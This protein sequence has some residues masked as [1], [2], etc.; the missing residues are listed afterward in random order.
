MRRCISRFNRKFHLA[1][2]LISIV[3]LILAAGCS[4]APVRDSIPPGSPKGYLVFYV[5]N[6]SKQS[7]NDLIIHVYKK[8]N[9]RQ[10][11]TGVLIKGSSEI[12]KKP[13]YFALRPGDHSFIIKGSRVPAEFSVKVN[14]GML[15]PVRLETDNI[16]SE[17]TMGGSTKYTTVTEKYTF[18]MN[19]IVGR[20]IPLIHGPKGLHY[21]KRDSIDA[22]ESLIDAL[23]DKDWGVRWFAA[24]GLGMIEESDA[25]K[26]IE[27]LTELSEKDPNKL[28]REV[29]RIALTK[30][31]K[32][33]LQ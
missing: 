25:A 14:D 33:K 18:D 13:F 29:A 16:I 24:D 21:V 19:A 3:V 32:T 17:A 27:R 8:S 9:G 12:R 30:I 31:S 5:Y 28:V 10:T 15:I 1:G 4:V 2:S 20:S 6:L 26:A 23:D 11:D 22:V 7:A